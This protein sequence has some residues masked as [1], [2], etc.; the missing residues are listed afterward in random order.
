MPGAFFCPV[1]PLPGAPQA[2][3]MSTCNTFVLKAFI[4]C[5]DTVNGGQYVRFKKHALPVGTQATVGRAGWWS[6]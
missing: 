1:P 4:A 2:T 3:R 6:V 5:G